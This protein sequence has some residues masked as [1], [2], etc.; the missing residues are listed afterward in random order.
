MNA[1]LVFL[2]IGMSVGLW[3]HP[4]STVI[5]ARVHVRRGHQLFL[6]GE[7]D[8]AAAEYRAAIRL[9]PN[10]AAAPIDMGIVLEAKGDLDGEI[11]EYRKAPVVSPPVRRRHAIT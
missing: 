7:L 10:N 11:A 2:I 8:G 9:D 3:A 5:D 1:K 6:Q 4:P